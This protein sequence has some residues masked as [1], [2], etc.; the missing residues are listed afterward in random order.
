MAHFDGREEFGARALGNRSILADPS[1]PGIVKP[2]NQ[3]IKCRDFWMPF[4][5]SVISESEETY[6]NNPKRFAAPYMILTFDS[7]HTE[8]IRAA[9]HPED[10]TV[11]PQ[12]VYRQW[13]PRYYRILELFQ[14]KTGRG[15]LL[16]TSFNIHGEPIV[17]SPVD[18]VDVFKRSGLSYL[19][20]GPYL[21]SKAIAEN[22]PQI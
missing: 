12:V 9:C 10:R 1:R 5:A 18:A 2:L 6:I 22:A 20:I 21:I 13:N 14:Q 17:S 16:N 3:A 19:A 7:R 15:A 11:R 4:A 8:E